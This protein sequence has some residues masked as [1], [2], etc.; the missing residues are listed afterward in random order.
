MIVIERNLRNAALDFLRS[1]RDRLTE[2]YV[3]PAPPNRALLR[4]GVD[5]FGPDLMDDTFRALNDSLNAAFPERFD[6][7]GSA[8]YESATAWIFA[9]LECALGY[10]HLGALPWETARR[11]AVGTWSRHLSRRSHVGLAIRLVR[12]L[13]TADGA[14]MRLGQVEIRPSGLRPGPELDELIPGG[15]RLVFE[16]ELTGFAPPYAVV[17]AR[18]TGDDALRAAFT[19]SSHIDRF[20][21]ATRLATCAT[22]DGEWELQGEQGPVRLL[23]PKWHPLARDHIVVTG[24]VCTVDARTARLIR[25]ASSLLS[26]SSA[27][28]HTKEELPS[29]P[30]S[31][32]LYRFSR[33][34]GVIN[35]YDAL[36]D[37]AIG[38]EAVLSTKGDAADGVSLRLRMRCAALLGLASDPAPAIYNDVKVL[39]GLRSRVAHGDDLPVKSLLALAD[40][41]SRVDNSLW[42]NP[43]MHAA[44]D[45]LR[46][47]LRRAIIA[48][49]VLSDIKH[50]WPASGGALDEAVS[51][52]D[53]VR[54]WRKSWASQLGRHR[55]ARLS[56]PASGLQDSL[57]LSAS[58]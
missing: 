42:P 15:S 31:V 23:T 7:V 57:S 6:Q 49:L 39:Y 14:A 17:I 9:L 52:I 18:V 53:W 51:D 29:S 36:M 54:Q 24:R 33:S 44:V 45:R 58:V 40:K 28:R 21:L 27:L 20:I 1:A 34:F 5:Y 10:E 11:R 3:L 56:E 19:A 32:A 41:V 48:R 8:S 13:T 47:L 30:V 37:T 4:I 55:A 26:K 38:L 50:G 12:H 46:D 35:W 22:V 25:T 2:L 43:K 16:G